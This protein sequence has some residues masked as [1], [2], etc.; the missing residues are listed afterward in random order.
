MDN[1]AAEN[2]EEIIQYCNSFGVI[3]LNFPPYLGHL[4]NICDNRV[5]GT[6]QK[7]LDR[8]QESFSNPYSPPL[9]E[10]YDAYLSAYASVTK[11]EILNSLASIGFGKLEN[12]REVERCFQRTLSEGLPN[13]REQHV[14]QLE[15]YLNDCIDNATPIPT[16]P[17][18]FRLPGELWDVYYDAL[19]FET[20]I[21]G[22]LPRQ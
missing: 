14:L 20:E 19:D 6:V 13:Q 18:A 17:Y 2:S 8:L 1:E 10:K 12:I 5:H 4:L 22:P 21:H 11:E 9:R 7:S 15:S 16:T 3:V